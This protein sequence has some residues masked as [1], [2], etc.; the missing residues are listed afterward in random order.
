[1]LIKSLCFINMIAGIELLQDFIDK[2]SDIYAKLLRVKKGWAMFD[3]L[4]NDIEYGFVKFAHKKNTEIYFIKNITKTSVYNMFYNAIIFLRRGCDP[5]IL[6]SDK[7]INK[8]SILYDVAVNNYKSDQEIPSG[9]LDYFE[10]HLSKANVPLKDILDYAKDD[11][12]KYYK[13]EINL[14]YIREKMNTNVFFGYF[15][16]EKGSSYY[17][18]DLYQFT[19]INDLT[20]KY[21]IVKKNEI[22]TDSNE[23]TLSAGV[24]ISLLCGYGILIATICCV[25]IFR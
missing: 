24:V 7:K 3:I 6:K 15:F 2:Q 21:E 23:S 10:N 16:A 17:K 22:N 25:L 11:I 13:Y 19:F 20:Y 1:M 9:I 4:L 18:S 8:P 14:E 12:K 5:R